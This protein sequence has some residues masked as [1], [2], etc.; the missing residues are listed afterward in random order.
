MSF[1]IFKAA[2][3]GDYNSSAECDATG[4]R[5]GQTKRNLGVVANVALQDKQT[6]INIEFV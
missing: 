6:H 1:Y 5:R 3:S 2:T 4:W